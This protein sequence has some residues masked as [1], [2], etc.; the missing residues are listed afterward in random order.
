M[1]ALSD[2]AGRPSLGHVADAVLLHGAGRGWAGRETAVPG[3][4]WM[5]VMAVTRQSE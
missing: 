5:A 3:A 2:S 4:S 1:E